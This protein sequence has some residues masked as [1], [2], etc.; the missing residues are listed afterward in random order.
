MTDPTWAYSDDFTVT[1][2][3]NTE[4]LFSHH[5]EKLSFSI[6]VKNLC[7]SHKYKIKSKSNSLLLF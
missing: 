1:G 3:N 4:L 7:L 6:N 5:D 2:D